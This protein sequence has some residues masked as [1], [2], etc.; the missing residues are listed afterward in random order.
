MRVDEPRDHAAP[1][2]VD[3]LVGDR[4]RALDGHHSAVV[5][6]HRSVPDEP[7]R[8]LA[9]RL[10]VGDEQADVVDDERAHRSASRSAAGTS[11]AAWRPSLTIHSPPT[12]TSRTSAAVAA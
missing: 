6:D 7:E 3:P 10:V 2:R 9:E 12:I 11:N 5:D 8:A 1:V 4:A